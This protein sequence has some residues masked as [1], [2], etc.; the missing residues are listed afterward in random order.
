MVKLSGACPQIE[1]SRCHPAALPGAV[2]CGGLTSAFLL[3][4]VRVL[5]NIF[6][7]KL[8]LFLGAGEVS[9]KPSMSLFNYASAVIDSTA[10]PTSLLF[11]VSESS[12][13]GL[14]CGSGPQHRPQTQPWL[15]GQHRPQTSGLSMAIH[16]NMA[17][18]GCTAQGH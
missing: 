8:L 16:I 4:V 13:Y 7:F 5:F 3:H 18:G 1:R 2:Y 17:L 12:D 14:P 9:Q 15:R 11:V 6:P 10:K